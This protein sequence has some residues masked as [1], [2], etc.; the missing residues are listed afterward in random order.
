MIDYLM[1]KPISLLTALLLT[2][3]TI[4][5]PAIPAAEAASASQMT[6]YRVYQNDKALKEFVTEAQATYYAKHYSYSHVEQIADRKWIWDNFPR[7]KV[8]QSGRSTSKMEF[9]SYNQALAYTKTLSNASIRD[10]ENVGWLYDTY[11]NY[12]LYQ[13]DNTLPT[14]NFRTLDDAK[15][16]AAKWGNVHVI[17]LSSGKWVWD[18]L[19]PA[20][21]NAQGST[22]AAYD[23]IVNG[24]VVEGEK[25]Y[26]FL[27]NAVHAADDYPGSE[28]LNTS[29]GKTVQSNV[30]TFELWQ[31][32]KLVRSYLGLR[33]AVK[34]ASS[35]AN[36]QVIQ[37]GATLWSS[38]PYLEVFQG[39]KKINTY[40]KLSS[41]L[42]YAKHYSN[43]SVRTLDGRMLWSNAKTLQFLGWNGSSA[44]S[45]IMS[46]VAN[47]Q[48][49]TYDSPTWF[50]LKDAS[51][52][53]IDS[54]NAGAVKT[55]K[56]KGILVTPLV[57]NG[58]DRK[59]TSEFLRS[60]A[61]QSTFI[62]SLV[63]KLTALGVY[64]VNLD[65]EEVAGADRSLYTS[66]VKALTA[67]AHAKGL[68]VSI[69][70]PRGDKSWNH[71]TAYDHAAI[72]GIVDMIMIMAYDE[73]WKG[74][75]EPGSV[76]G[77]KWTEEGVKQFLDYGVPRNKLMLGI[78]FYVREWRVDAS[79]KLVDNRAILMKELP[80]LIADNK[81]IG[82]WDAESGQTKYTYAKDGYTHMFWAETSQ[83]VLARM[84]IAKKYDLAGVAAWRLGY[85]DAELWTKMLQAK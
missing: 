65:F 14:W 34:A 59:M 84:D 37:S 79:G 70:L 49:L 17:D 27:R 7:Y 56:D 35:L 78:P 30:Q 50:E 68:K 12:R 8:Y 24:A 73:H 31:N 38:Q 10:L 6:K 77:L 80:K 85:E 28:I 67:A 61:A 82:V 47:T 83:T 41:A 40:H 33:D 29:T 48:G 11:P 75:T 25:R 20:Q 71:L 19:T 72:A 45:T 52:A 81:A 43:S 32:D 21:V 26:S 60:T 36:A 23:I 66:F 44:V 53:L 16:E 39:S 62:T 9:Q 22:P 5:S 1:W 74:S 63:S 46:H 64:G 2:A 13:G 69:D 54:S 3:G 15:K 51:G 76:A 42:Y 57:H 55:L 58:F 18:N 4:L